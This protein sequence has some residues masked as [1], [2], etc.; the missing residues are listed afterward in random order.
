MTSPQNQHTNRPAPTGRAVLFDR[1]PIG[2]RPLVIGAISQP[3]TLKRPD[4]ATTLKLHIAEFR[5]DLTGFVTG[6]QE[7]ARELRDAGIPVLLTLRS[8][9][10][11]GNWTGTET[12]RETAYASALPHISALDIEISSP[13]AA[14]VT[15]AAHAAGKSVILSFH[16]FDKT[17]PIEQLRTTIARGHQLGADIVKIAT[18]TETQ[19]DLEILRTLLAER[20][21][22]LLCCVG[23]GTLG[24][25]SRTELPSF[26]SCLTYGH[27]DGANAPG[28]PSSADLLA[29]LAP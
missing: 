13:V 7:R 27:A 20:G 9:E 21:T 15:R 24:P 25:A 19:P 28:Q 26:G 10:E 23:M 12:G 18:R 16:D 14:A 6:W 11:R 1:L 2:P 17:P 3:G 22:H 5:L 8:R 29:R 4:L